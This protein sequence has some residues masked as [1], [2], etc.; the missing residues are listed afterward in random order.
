MTLFL[1]YQADIWVEV[2]T[3]EED[4]VSVIVDDRTMATPVDVL[5]D[6]GVDAGSQISVLARHVADSR[7]W[8]SWDYGL[9]PV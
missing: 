8:P 2:D 7:C 1:R 5:D 9:R 6:R 3:D 4:V